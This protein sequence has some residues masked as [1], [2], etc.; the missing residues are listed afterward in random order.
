MSNSHG[1]DELTIETLARLLDHTLLAPD[2]T[3]EDVDRAC[4]EAIG[5][6][7]AT[8][9]VCPY[10]VARAAEVLRGSDVLVGGTVGIPFGHAGPCAKRA[11]AKTCVEAGAGEI[12]MVINL[13][14][15]KSG[16]YA[17]VRDEIADVRKIATGLTLKVILEC[18][19]LSDEEKARAAELALEAGADFVK[20][21][22]GFGPGGATVHDVRLLKQVVG[23]HA[24]VKAA[25]GIRTFPEAR[26]LLEAGASR[27]G[28]RTAVEIIKD[29]QRIKV[30]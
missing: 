28:T 15:M 6:G 26:R 29:F 19:Y 4:Q 10:D 17:D 14:A 2:H 1:T 25:G 18:C 22:T 7:F 3:V 20:T 30:E 27:L 24:R 11:E 9:T 8:V 13:I 21:S 12:D 16:R 23:D 5:Y